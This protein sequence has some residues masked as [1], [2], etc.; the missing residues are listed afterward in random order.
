MFAV[1]AL[2]VCAPVPPAPD[3]Q[4]IANATEW[5][6]SDKAA[7][8]VHSASLDQPHYDVKTDPK[9]AEYGGRVTFLRDGKERFTLS[10]HSNTVFR[11]VGDTLIYASFLTS[12]SGATVIAV[13][14]KTGKELWKTK[15]KGIGL[16]MHFA[17]SNY[18]NMEADAGTITVFGNESFGRYVE[19]LDTKTGK[20]V[21]HKK[22]L[23]EKPEPKP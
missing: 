6:W 3:Y 12:A 13:D 7:T 23:K 4:K 5:T 14:L 18:L 19:I 2:A 9:A 11:I 8:L 10:A 16:V 22:F 20:T 1:I 15:L 17:Y 21:G